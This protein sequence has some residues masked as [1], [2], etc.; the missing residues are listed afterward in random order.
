MGTGCATGCVLSVPILGLATFFVYM[1]NVVE[2]PAYFVGWM[3]LFYIGFTL[4]Q[5][6]RSTW[7]PAIAGRL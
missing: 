3:I 5:T 1:P 2:S 7:V 6:A 4:L